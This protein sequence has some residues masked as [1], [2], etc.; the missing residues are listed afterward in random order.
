MNLQQ[1][2][3]VVEIARRD[4]NISA[5]ASALHTSQSGIS[6]QV[7]QLERELG[8]EIFTRSRSRLSGTTDVGLRVI[9]FAGKALEEIANIRLMSLEQKRP[10]AGILKIATSH[11]HARYVLADV[12]KRF[13]ERNPKVRISLLYGHPG[14]IPEMVQ[15]GQAD[16]G[17]TT[18]TARGINALMTLQYRR[19]QRVVIVP[20]GHELL[21]VKRLTLKALARYPLITY[22]PQ[23]TGRRDL[24]K[25]FEKSGLTPKLL[26]SAIDADVI[27]MCVE[28]GMGIAVLSEVAFD[29]QRDTALRSIFAGHLFEHSTTSL[30]LHRTR[31]LPEYVYDFVATCLPT[32]TKADVQR[33]AATK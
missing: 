18:D 19:F 13:A 29:E 10:A 28:Q 22:E 14:Q 27:K 1:L 11:T 8:L 24:V 4:F 12:M 25:A 7:M 31:F 20:I 5:V 15:S 33:A 6:K 2:R 32:W 26:V 17:V 21:R 3:Y 23:F 30:L 16:I 9:T